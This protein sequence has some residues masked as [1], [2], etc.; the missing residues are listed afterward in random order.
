MKRF[1]LWLRLMNELSTPLTQSEA[2][3]K[4]CQSLGL[5][6]QRFETSRGTCLVQSRKLPL[7]GR[8][9]LISRGPI[10]RDKGAAQELIEQA[11]AEIR[12]PLFVNATSAPVQAGGF[13]LI[14]G[15]ELALIH[16]DQPDEMRARM[17]QKWRNQLCKAERSDLTIL[18]QSLDAERHKWFLAAEA[19]QQR[20]QRYSSYPAGF[21][22]AYAAANKGDARV[23]TAQLQGQSVAAM[24][25]LRHGTMATYQ[26]GV[27]TPEGRR[28]CAHNLL[29][30]QMMCDHERHGGTI[31]DLGRADLS[32]GLRRFKLG[33]GAE[34]EHLAGTYWMPSWRANRRG[35]KQGMKAAA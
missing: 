20:S 35:R 9:N 24:L 12:G 34:T 29:L 28:H 21:L 26:A 1:D 30:W 11:R 33:S 5:A 2:F 27:T 18:N 8:I 19:E 3:E 14:S 25:M 31:L 4:T 13:R 32:P 17:G 6:V 23:F 7:L 16:L 22:L 15:A 10:A